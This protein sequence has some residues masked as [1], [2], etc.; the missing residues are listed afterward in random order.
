MGFYVLSFSTQL[1]LFLFFCCVFCFTIHV[2]QHVDALRL[3]RQGTLG[4][5]RL[6]KHL[7]AEPSSRHQDMGS[8]KCGE[9][10]PEESI[11]DA[12]LE[13]IYIPQQFPVVFRHHNKCLRNDDHER[14]SHV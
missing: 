11:R 2:K 6:P 12:F 10:S 1:L 13:E 8:V 9:L 7:G 3:L 4:S 5:K 14:C